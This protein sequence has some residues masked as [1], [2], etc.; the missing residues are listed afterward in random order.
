[1]SRK[2]YEGFLPLSDCEL[3]DSTPTKHILSPHITV[4]IL[5]Q[6]VHTEQ[7]SA[8]VLECILI[9]FADFGEQAVL[10]YDVNVHVSFLLR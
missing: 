3:L 2:G 9:S 5:F 8:A 6:F 7:T 4:R 10:C 1:M